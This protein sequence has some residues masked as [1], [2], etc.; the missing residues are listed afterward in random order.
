[1]ARLGFLKVSWQCDSAAE[2]FRW[3]CR[4]M[5]EIQSQPGGTPVGGTPRRRGM[6]MD[7]NGPQNATKQAQGVQPYTKTWVGVALTLFQTPRGVVFG[8]RPDPQPVRRGVRLAQ[9]RDAAVQR[10]V[11]PARGVQLDR[12]RP[13]L[14]FAEP[15]NHNPAAPKC[16]ETAGGLSLGFRKLAL[17]RHFLRQFPFQR[18]FRAI[19]TKIPSRQPVRGCLYSGDLGFLI[20]NSNV[21]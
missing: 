12:Q 14:A 17:D 16:P 21:G 1:M 20:P 7:T 15:S 10:L 9:Q 19:P 8:H 11:A 2:A 5:A 4:S 3:D 18:H 13:W 6:P